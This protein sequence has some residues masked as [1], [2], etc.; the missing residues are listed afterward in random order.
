VVTWRFKGINLPPNKHPPEGEGWVAYSVMP[1]KDV[2]SGTVIRNKALIIFDQNEPMATPEV[3]NTID[4]LPPSSGVATLPAKEPI[5][6]FRISVAGA[7]DKQGSGIKNYAI[8]VSDNGAP[9]APWKTTTPDSTTVQFSGENNHTYEFYSVATDN[10]GHVEAAPGKPDVVTT[11]EQQPGV[12]AS[13]DPFV[14]A[15]GHTA[16]SFFGA[17]VPGVKLRIYNKSGELVQTLEE[18]ENEDRFDWEAKSSNG[19]DLASGI[20]IYVAEGKA[21]DKWKGKFGII[22]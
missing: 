15:R 7:D 18:T 22:R 20:Y 4:A 5:S 11:V 19:K 1:K 8:Y 21:G 14:P 17:G 3:I 2:A 10:V 12:Q 6:S 16:I 13:P 9:Y